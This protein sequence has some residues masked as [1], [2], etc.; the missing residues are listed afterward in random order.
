M[1]WDA[2][3]RQVANSL[4]AMIWMC[5][6]DGRATLFNK[7]WLHFTGCTLPQAVDGGWAA[8]VH[9]DDVQRRLA[10][11]DAAWQSRAPFE[12]EYRLRRADGEFRWMLDQ[13]APQFNARGDFHGYVG[14]AIDITERKRTED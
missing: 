3:L 10:V 2:L 7:R 12:T 4:P 11:Y 1:Q 8:W 13:A 14:L 9:P 5:G 6:A